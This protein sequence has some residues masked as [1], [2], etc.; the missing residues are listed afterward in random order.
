M[1]R[2]NALS[3]K[4]YLKMIVLFIAFGMLPEALVSQVVS[5]I[6]LKEV[7]QKKVRKFIISGAFDKMRD[8][9]LIRSSWKKDAIESDF[10]IIEKTY[11]LKAG[12]AIVWNTY[13]HVNS[14]DMWNSRLVKFGLLI[15]KRTNTVT[16]RDN[17]FSPE[18]DTGQVYFLDLRLMKGL[19]NLPVAF[20]IT[21]IDQKD[22]IIE[23]TYL[24]KNKSKGK[25]TIHIIDG[26][27]GGTSIV[28]RTYFSSGSA[29]RDDL[30][31]FFHKRFIKEFHRNMNR[32]IRKGTIV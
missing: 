2:R 19:L 4:A 30:Y 9:S 11:K 25:Q 5:S 6:N 22:Q 12:H 20:E 26:D 21:R 3:G 32:K 16:Y 15:S 31:P 27:N 29:F 18:L 8:F 1:I 28:H 17:D 13:R 7:P 24:E 14:I 10:R 23:F